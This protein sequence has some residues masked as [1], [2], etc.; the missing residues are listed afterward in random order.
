MIFYICVTPVL[1][2]A[3]VVANVCDNVRLQHL[4][5]HLYYRIQE[6]GNCSRRCILMRDGFIFGGGIGDRLGHRLRVYLADGRE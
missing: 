6:K 2:A 3:F 4:Q 5:D 1:L